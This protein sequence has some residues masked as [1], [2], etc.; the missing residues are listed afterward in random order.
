M[1]LMKKRWHRYHYKNMTYLLLSLIVAFLLFK[2]E[3]LHNF[4]QSLGNLGYFG[5]IIGGALFVSTFTVAAGTIILL[6]LAETLSLLEIGILAGIGAV[7]GD[8]TIFQL[9]RSRGMIDEIKHLFDYLGWDKIYHLWHTKYF[10]WTLPV[11]GAIIIASP[12]PDEFGVSLMGISRLKTA[13]FIGLSFLLNSI[14]II[15]VISAS[16]FIRP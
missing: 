14:G 12:L 13:Q 6:I 16:S 3:S 15:L 8:L 2:S 9:I 4:L 10:S 5:A 1:D 7:I 11:V